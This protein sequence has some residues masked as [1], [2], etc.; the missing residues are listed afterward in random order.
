[1]QSFRKGKNLSPNR[2]SVNRTQREDN[3]SPQKVEE[4]QV[5]TFGKYCDVNLISVGG[6]T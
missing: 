3:A 5:Y 1:M 2:T 6:G 4:N